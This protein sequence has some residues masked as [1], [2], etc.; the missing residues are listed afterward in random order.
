M[1]TNTQAVLTTDDLNDTDQR[2]LD[3]LRDGRV[4]PQYAADEAGISRTYASERLKRLVE[5]GHVD[6]LAAGLYELADD[7]RED[8]D[9]K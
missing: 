6:K 3:V 5:H 9:E 1:G 7:P 8:N 2:V 4:T